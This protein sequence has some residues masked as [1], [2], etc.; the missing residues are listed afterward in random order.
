MTTTTSEVDHDIELDEL[1]A[2]A[3][4]HLQDQG[5]LA[6]SKAV[7]IA[8]QRL[9]VPTARLVIQEA[10]PIVQETEAAQ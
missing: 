6:L 1:L 5:M 4:T 3:A 7:E 8:R 10:D 2:D 9:G